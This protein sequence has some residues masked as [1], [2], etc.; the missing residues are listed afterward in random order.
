[1]DTPNS[2]NI[3]NEAEAKHW[4]AMRVVGY[5]ADGKI[6]QQ[7]DEAGIR[8]YMPMREV[9]RVVH[10]K[11]VKMV[12]PVAAGLM[13]TYGSES[14]ILVHTQRSSNRFQFLIPRG[15]HIRDRIVIRDEEMDSFISVAESKLK[16]DY[17]T[18]EEAKRAVGKKV[19]ILGGVFNNVIGKLVSPPRGKKQTLIVEVEGLMAV[20]VQLTPDLI[21]V[22]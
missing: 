20:S 22:L 15:G 13:F 21:Q 18:V 11:T 4:Y 8:Y 7:L 14:E 12:V 6:R 9:A 10:G 2:E 16:H 5:M 1:M 17:I 19:K 3:I